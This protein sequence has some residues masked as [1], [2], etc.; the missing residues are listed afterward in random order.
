VDTRVRNQI[1]L[2]LVQV[3]VQSA[4]ETKTRSDG[5]HD[6]SNE[7]IEMLVTWARNIQV[8]AADVIDSLII[9]QEGAVRIFDSAMG[10]QY[11]VVWLYD[12]GRDARSRIDGELQLRLLAV[13]R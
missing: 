1:R 10:R 9:D 4:V 2:E 6:L 7:T 8:P 11:R 13:F 12:R 5:A 3:H